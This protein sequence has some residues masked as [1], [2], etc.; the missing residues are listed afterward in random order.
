MTHVRAVAWDVDG[1]LV[2]S[3]PLHLRSLQAACEKFGVDISDHGPAPFVGVAIASVW[4][5]LSTRFEE[6]LGH[7]A[8]RGERIFRAAVTEYYL[9][10]AGEV[11]VL[12]GARE[13][14]EYLF[15]HGI[16]LA[17]VSNS[18]RAIVTAN[19]RTLGVKAR[20]DAIVSLDDVREAK[21]APE[22]YTRALG[23]LGVPTAV[24]WAV[25][26]SPSGAR[27][28]RAAGLRVLVVGAD[29][30][31]EGDHRMPGL[32]GFLPWWRSLESRDYEIPSRLR[33]SAATGDSA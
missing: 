31:A 14:L 29:A 8:D 1:T 16:A 3:E 33:L 30:D 20:F 12:P 21:P 32:A 27:S 11:V 5:L 7:H 4:R 25:E 22:P 9:A 24:A 28:A 2:D 15:E 13:A 26:D 18:E 17:A 19:L 6:A 23:I 10:N